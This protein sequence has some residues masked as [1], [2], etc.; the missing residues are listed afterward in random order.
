M[1]HLSLIFMVPLFFLLAS[2]MSF[3]KMDM[4][5]FTV[6]V[7]YQEDEAGF[8]NKYDDYHL[9]SYE[10]DEYIFV[11]DAGTG[12]GVIRA[13]LFSDDEGD[14]FAYGVRFY[15]KDVLMGYAI[16]YVVP[17]DRSQRAMRYYYETFEYVE[18]DTG[19]TMV[20]P[21]QEAQRKEYAENS[22]ILVPIE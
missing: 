18:T 1:K 6:L 13:K 5:E 19:T 22:A 17:Q 20:F 14:H 8:V 4:E 2:C 9:V 12:H 7:S 3:G 21:N 16:D 10:G 11:E 15:R